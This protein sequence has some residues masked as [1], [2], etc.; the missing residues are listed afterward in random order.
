MPDNALMHVLNQDP[1]EGAVR[2]QPR[3]DQD[4]LPALSIASVLGA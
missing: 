2:R 1:R 4:A 3:T